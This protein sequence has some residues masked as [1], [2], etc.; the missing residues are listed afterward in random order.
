MARV[1]LETNMSLFIISAYCQ[2]FEVDIAAH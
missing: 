1:M 2:E